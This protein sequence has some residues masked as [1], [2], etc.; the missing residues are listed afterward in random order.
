MKVTIPIKFEYIAPEIPEDIIDNSSLIISFAL[1]ARAAFIISLNEWY[2]KNYPDF[3][4]D[5]KKEFEE[6]VLDILKNPSFY[7][8]EISPTAIQFK[9]EE[10]REEFS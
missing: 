9:A 2:I 8:K 1:Q 5:M 10:I 7:E 6:G 3:D 4:E